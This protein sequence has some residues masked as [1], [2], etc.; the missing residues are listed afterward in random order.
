MIKPFLIIQLRPEDIVA[1]DE[2][3]AMMRYGGLNS[4]EIHRVRIDKEP[5]PNVSL[6]NYSG[7]IL[8]GS[9]YNAS[10]KNKSYA[11]RK[12]EIDLF[13]MFNIIVSK[14]VPYLGACYG[15]G[16]LNYYLGGT[17][18]KERYS[19]GVG[20]VTVELN[21][22]A[23]TDPILEG[24]PRTFRAFVGHK[25]ACQNLPNKVIS[26]ASSK[27]C[28]FQM[29]RVKKN[30]YATQF[31]PELDPAGLALRINAYKYAGYFPP[32][33]AE[34]LIAKAME[35]TVK[36]PAKILNRFVQIYSKSAYG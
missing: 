36:I 32:E 10:D 6:E 13:N 22:M 19:E 1:D 26:L 35:E 31:H 33:A 17:V 9:P 8:G 20:A 3:S 11:Q 18:S 5:L 14:D 21:D 7:V 4:S 12:F 16:I 24:L 34:T 25:E 15:L 23:K 27:T 29:V 28:V 30:I 2:F